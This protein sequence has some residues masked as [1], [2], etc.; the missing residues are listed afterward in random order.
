MKLTPTKV[1]LADGKKL[2]GGYKVAL[3]KSECEKHGFKAGDELKAEFTDKEIK[4]K[5]Q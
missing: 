5:K 4:L 3:P 2:I 1:T